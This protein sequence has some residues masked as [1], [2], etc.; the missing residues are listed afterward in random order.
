MLYV[1]R[2]IRREVRAPVANL[3]LMSITTLDHLGQR[4]R[5]D[6]LLLAACDHQ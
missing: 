2:A 6:W 5:C 4:L 1:V 3:L